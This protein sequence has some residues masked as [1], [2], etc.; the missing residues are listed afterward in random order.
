MERVKKSKSL[1]YG[2][3]VGLPESTSLSETSEEKRMI[4]PEDFATLKDIVLLTPDGCAVIKK[5]P[6]YK[7]KAF[8]SQGKNWVLP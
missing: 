4:K 1:H 6:H 7:V 8:Q 3:D 5:T 2:R